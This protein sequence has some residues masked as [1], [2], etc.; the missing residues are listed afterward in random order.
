MSSASPEAAH[1]G[2]VPAV[3]TS[4]QV[5]TIPLQTMISFPKVGDLW[6]DYPA[7]QAPAKEVYIAY[8][9][10]ALQNVPQGTSVFRSFGGPGVYLV[11]VLNDANQKLQLSWGYL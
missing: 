7:S 1:A 9:G 4:V 10:S 8:G 11:Y 6:I 5:N 3:V 2:T